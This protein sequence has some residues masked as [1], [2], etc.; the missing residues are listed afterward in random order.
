MA[1]DIN[2]LDM[3]D[4]LSILERRKGTYLSLLLDEVESLFLKNPKVTYPE[5][6][7]LILDSYNDYFR[8]FIRVVIGDIEK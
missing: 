8:S 2:G 5:V 6:R 3:T 4:V 7:K 1:N